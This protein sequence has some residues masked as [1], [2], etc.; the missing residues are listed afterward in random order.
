MDILWTPWR[1]SYISSADKISECI[2]CKAFEEPEKYHVVLR[3]ESSIA[4]LNAYPYNTAHVMIAPRRHVP[5]I[6][7]LED[8]EI[9]DLVRIL[10]KIIKAIRRE[11]NPQG[12]NIGVNIGRIAGAGIE[13]HLH[14]HVV[15]RWS[16]DTNFLPIISGAKTIPEDLETT[17]RRIM[18]ALEEDRE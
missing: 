17:R 5:D 11:Y 7:F 10:K 4:L 18:K 12:F 9:L 6:I 14:I 8:D 3:S 2:F 16:G 13:S 1:M 15:P